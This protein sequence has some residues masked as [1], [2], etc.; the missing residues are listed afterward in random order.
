[1]SRQ[2][3]ASHYS[4]DEQVVLE[5]GKWKVTEDGEKVWSLYFD[6]VCVDPVTD[7]NKFQRFDI[8]FM[9]YRE[10]HKHK[11]YALFAN[12]TSI[13]VFT[14]SGPDVKVNYDSGLI[15]FLNESGSTTFD[16]HA[17]LKVNFDLNDQM[18][19]QF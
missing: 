7:Y 13:P 16:T 12:N 9:L 15:T 14:I 18:G 4:N 3:W 19:I 17:L 8:G 2:N 11:S 1:M 5:S 10:S 6:G